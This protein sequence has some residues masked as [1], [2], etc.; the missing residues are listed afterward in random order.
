M[1]ADTDLPRPVIVQRDPRTLTRLQ[2]NARFMTK[3]QYDQLVANIRRDGCLTS[4][5]LI[6]A[7]PGCPEGAETILSGNHRCDAAVEAGLDEVTCMLI[8]GELSQARRIAIQLSHNSIAGED[9]PATLAKLYEDIDDVDWRSYAGLDDKTLDLLRQVELDSISE[10][11]LDF[12]TVSLVFLPPEL[13]AAREALDLARS[14]A[15]ETWLAARSDYEPMLAALD[16]A[17][18]SHKIGNVATAL[19]IVLAVF[20]AHLSDLQAGYLGPDGEALHGGQ[21]GIESALGCRVMPAAAAAVLARAVRRA[22]ETGDVEAGKE[23]ALLEIMADRY[24]TGGDA[25][26]PA[27]AG[28]H[29]AADQPAPADQLTG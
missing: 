10:A 28:Q 23:W 25:A 7:P 2:V 16:S 1:S 18:A 14:G 11:N 5:P 3:E 29:D 13:Q 15:D 27:D 24:L 6:W 19:A 26:R 12:A 22:V 21:V 8:E 17:R 20:E 4:V 9:D